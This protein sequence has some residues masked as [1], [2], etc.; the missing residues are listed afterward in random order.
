MKNIILLLFLTLTVS[1]QRDYWTETEKRI[2]KYEEEGKEIIT[3]SFD[4]HIIIYNDNSSIWIDNLDE[5]P[6]AFLTT[7]KEM[8]LNYYHIEWDN[9]GAPYIELFSEPYLTQE[10]DVKCWSGKKDVTYYDYKY[11]YDN[12]YYFNLCKNDSAVYFSYTEE[13]YDM[14]GSLKEYTY[15]YIYYFAVPGQLFKLNDK[16]TKDNFSNYNVYDNDLIDYAISSPSSLA[17]IIIDPTQMN[18]EMF[19]YVCNNNSGL[20]YWGFKTDAKGKIYYKENN[21]TYRNNL[22]NKEINFS[23]S[24][25][26]SKDKALEVL[27]TIN[28]TIKNISIRKLKE[29]IKKSA[30]TL[31]ELSDQF[32]NQIKSERELIGKQIILICNFDV[33]KK[34]DGWFDTKG[35]KYKLT[36]SATEVMDTW[37]SGYDVIAYTNDESFTELEFP[38][39]V[40]M[41]C[42]VVSGSSRYFEFKECRLLMY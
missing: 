25:F 42:T 6:K 31:D 40:I 5:E 33:I 37:W 12:Q 18:S 9:S 38:K 4:R 24:D 32:K 39:S 1:C 26:S 13:G 2:K 36:S 16:F 11:A 22:L 35:Y 30:I 19:E 23:I 20:F 29:E 8:Q 21:I 17:N 10:I 34:A 41:Q 27:K 3:K 14:D 7:G 28:D 15:D